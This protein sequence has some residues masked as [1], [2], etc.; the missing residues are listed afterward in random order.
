MAFS[1]GSSS[2]GARWLKNFLTSHAKREDPRIEVLLDTSDEREAQSYGARFTLG[3]RTTSLIELDF[4]DVAT[5]RGSYAWCTALAQ[6]VRH[7]A[8]EQLLTAPTASA[9]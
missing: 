8:R 1:G 9:R 3:E 5:N 6:R 7:V 4:H 2:D